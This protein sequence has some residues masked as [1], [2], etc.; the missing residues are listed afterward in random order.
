MY[1]I[2]NLI[3]LTDFQQGE[4][5]NARRFV[6]FFYWHATKEVPKLEITE[7]ARKGY[8]GTNTGRQVT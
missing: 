2:Q 8:K 4:I 3:H 1:Y 5:R 6:T 7:C